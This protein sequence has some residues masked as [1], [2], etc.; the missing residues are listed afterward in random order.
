MFEP[1]FIFASSVL[2]FL[3]IFTAIFEWKLAQERKSLYLLVAFATLTLSGILHLAS[4]AVPGLYVVSHGFQ[5]WG[6][7]LISYSLLSGKERAGTG[8]KQA[9]FFFLLLIF[10][11]ILASGPGWLGWEKHQLGVKLWQVALA[12][13]FIT[14]VLRRDHPAKGGLTVI[15][16][17]WFLMALWRP[18]SFQAMLQLFI[19]LGFLLVVYGRVILAFRR[20]EKTKANLVREKEVILS[21]LGR[22]GAALHDA[23]NLE[24]V[25]KMIM[26]CVMASSQAKAGAIFLL[27][28]DKKE[29]TV[30]VVE[31]LFPP[32]HKTIDKATTRARFIMEKFKAD[33]IK[34][35]EGVIGQVAATG[36]SIL[37]KDALRDPRTPEIS[38]DFLQ[39]KTMVVAPLKVK[40]EVVGVI[41]LINKEKDE[42]FSEVDDSLL[43]ALGNQA[44]ISINSAKLYQALS[45]KERLERE[46]QIA[47]DIQRFLLPKEAPRI[48]GFEVA[49][50]ARP[51]TEVGGDYYDYFEVSK[52][53][54]GL[55]IADVSGKGV[56]GALIMAMVRSILRAEAEGKSSAA[57]VL[58]RVNRSIYRDIKDDMFVSLFYL[59]L[60]VKKRTLNYA[61]AG[62]DPSI[63][64]HGQ[65]QR[66]ELLDKGGIALGLDEGSFFDETLD[67]G[68]IELVP[69]D[70]LVLYTD[71]ITEAM[72]KNNEEFGFP[73][74]L[75]IVRQDSLAE[76][77]DKAS[78]LV[79]RVDQE[80]TKFTGGVP[81]RD[82]I[83]LV[84]LK[85]Q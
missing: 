55:V 71:G 2:A 82:D 24:E 54:W 18:G 78:V 84:V 67:Q 13:T 4:S 12:I 8:W 40:E 76:G 45:E 15:F 73:Q 27:S 48:E 42:L 6:L 65:E 44:A 81:Q 75:E 62:H 22:I 31:G 19:Y 30:D 79:E 14:F 32:L 57:Q 20:I 56:P 68:E 63:L 60:N 7:I 72:N 23:F 41:A 50:L 59:V 52:D 53:E 51:A 64:F 35:G 21:F 47:R 38:A 70:T 74:L 36:R 77:K 46:L 10:S 34:V 85:V 49:S 17:L 66:Y 29:L 5:A 83:T 69:G 3:G 39:V 9:G 80:I 25:L 11:L 37:I 33:R 1:I 26:N 58:S 43:H 61:R 16:S 28:D